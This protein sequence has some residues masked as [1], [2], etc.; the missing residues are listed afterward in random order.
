MPERLRLH[1]AGL[2]TEP[3]RRR[4]GHSSSPSAMYGMPCDAEYRFW[5]LIPAFLAEQL[6]FVIHVSGSA[7]HHLIA[8]MRHFRLSC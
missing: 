8:L 4:R 6:R 3:F 7:L 5:D 2:D 1:Q